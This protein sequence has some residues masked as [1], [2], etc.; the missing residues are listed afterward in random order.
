MIQ[1]RCSSLDRIDAC[2]GSAHGFPDKSPIDRETEPRNIGSA[3]HLALQQMID[4][5]RDY[6]VDADI[7]RAAGQFRVDDVDDLA[8]VARSAAKVWREE[9]KQYFN[10]GPLHTERQLAIT[11]GELALSGHID[12]H[13]EPFELPPV[14]TGRQRAVALL[15]WKLGYNVDARCE[16]QMRGYA[17]LLLFE[18]PGVAEVHCAVITGRDGRWASYKWTG[19]E[20]RAWARELIQKVCHW[21]G[22][23]TIGDHCTYC[24]W[25]HC[26]AAVRDY[27]RKAIAVFAN[28]NL[29]AQPTIELYRFLQHVEAR[30]K[31]ARDAVRTHLENGGTIADDEYTL[32]RVWNDRPKV[33]AHKAWPLFERFTGD[34]MATFVTIKKTKMFAAVAAQ[35]G[36]G[37]K[38][39]EKREF[40][41]ALIAG[42][43]MQPYGYHSL[44]LQKKEGSRS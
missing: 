35:V 29:A 1:V 28:G 37:Q 13:S 5:G 38:G 6:V 26:C 42:G 39:N 7:T 23:Y 34:E 9:V 41:Q 33:D 19:D 40:E 21:D 25:Q 14:G 8:I 2:P 44:R 22:R 15:D 16:K 31:A 24:P 20:L 18:Y 11:I 30:A 27:D 10:P 43:A 36:R 4:A 3:G 32:V 17:L 12:V